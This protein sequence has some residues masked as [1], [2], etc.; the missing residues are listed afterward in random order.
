MKLLVTGGAGYTDGFV[1]AQLLAKEHTVTV[2]E[3]HSGRVSILAPF[4]EHLPRRLSAPQ[5]PT[6]RKTRQ[7]H[8]NDQ[9]PDVRPPDPKT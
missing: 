4:T 8:Q 9:A 5:R 2:L 3:V 6:S 1:V 7:P